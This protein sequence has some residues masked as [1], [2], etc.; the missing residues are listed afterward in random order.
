MKLSKKH[1]FLF[2]LLALLIGATIYCYYPPFKHF[3]H[4]KL[5]EYVTEV[6]NEYGERLTIKVKVGG[7][8]ASL[9]NKPFTASWL[10][11]GT[12]YGDDLTVHSIDLSVS[13]S[14]SGNKITNCRISECYWHCEEESNPSTNYVDYYIVQSG[15]PVSV[16]L[17]ANYQGSWSDS[18]S[19]DLDTHLN[20]M[21]LD[22]APTENVTYIVHYSFY[23]LVEADGEISGNILSAEIPLT[24]VA[25]IKFEY[26]VYEELNAEGSGSVSTSSWLQLNVTNLVIIGLTVIVIVLVLK[27]GGRRNE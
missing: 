16:T 21:T 19:T 17:D 25:F 9:T 12:D 26:T 13:V 5:Q 18:Y 6:E 27:K 11:N 14:I 10:V 3:L 22:T 7:Q 24:E 23:V 15:S 2:I 20:D 4:E 1:L 8:T